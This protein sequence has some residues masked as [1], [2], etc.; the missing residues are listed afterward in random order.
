M[1][2]DREQGRSTESPPAAHRQD[3]LEGGGRHVG[4]ASMALRRGAGRRQP[5]GW[6]GGRRSVGHLVVAATG[7]SSSKRCTEPLP[8]LRIYRTWGGWHISGEQSP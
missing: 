8:Q 7:P 5:A 4:G 2:R 6:S 1:A 3:D